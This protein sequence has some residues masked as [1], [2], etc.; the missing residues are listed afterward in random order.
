MSI[1]TFEKSTKDVDSASRERFQ[2]LLTKLDTQV[3]RHVAGL[4]DENLSAVRAK[5][6]PTTSPASATTKSGLDAFIKDKPVRKAKRLEADSGFVERNL[7]EVKPWFE[8]IKRHI[9]AIVT[10]GLSSVCMVAVLVW[11]FSNTTAWT[12][13]AR[14]GSAFD[15][16]GAKAQAVIAATPPKVSAG[17]TPT[18]SSTL[19]PPEP[20]PADEKVIQ[21][22]LR[23]PT[24][25]VTTTAPAIKP[26]APKTLPL[27]SKVKPQS[28]PEQLVPAAAVPIATA[29]AGL[30]T[31]APV[32][33]SPSGSN[34]SGAALALNLC[35]ASTK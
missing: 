24:A 27:A 5:K 29:S 20:P 11:S 9:P 21:P 33:A 28:T 17:D 4:I 15:A 32:T 7:L 8:K 34:C 26:D 23:L 2:E 30:P 6:V 16:L 13:P 31:T 35:N 18:Q 22:A 3:N 12:D 25:P 10:L 1:D 14:Q 19:S